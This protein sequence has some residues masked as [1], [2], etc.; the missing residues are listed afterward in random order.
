MRHACDRPVLAFLRYLLLHSILMFA[1][2]DW[3]LIP[4]LS[5]VR[6]VDLAG[7]R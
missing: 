5:S 7:S 1:S 3:I 2:A 6:Y 4:F